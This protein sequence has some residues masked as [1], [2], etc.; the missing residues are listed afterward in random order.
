M[1]TQSERGTVRIPAGDGAAYGPAGRSAWLDVDWREHQRWVATSGG[2]VNAV[3]LGSGPPVLF[4]HGLSGCWPN[5]LEQL[6]ALAGS[7]R[8]IAID[9]PGFGHSPMPSRRI[10]MA[11]YAAMLDELLDEL[12]V[13]AA[14]VVGNSMGG[15]IACELAI[16]FP[17]RVQRL[18]LVSAAGISTQR[19]AAGGANLIWMQRL[20]RALSGGG[21]YFARRAETVARH[22]R[23]RE[24]GLA[25][26]VAHPG[27]LPPAISCELI[28]GAGKPG[29]LP[30]LTSMMAHELRS[31]LAL[32]RCPTLVVWGERDRAV[33]VRDGVVFAHLIGDARLVVFEDTGHVAMVERPE[34]F[35]AL[36]EE[37]LG[38]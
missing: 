10:S 30:A 22:R 17:E 35:N 5:W 3:D 29:F 15:L 18:V 26:F 8:V 23:L 14:A 31:R 25:P 33:S 16:S 21:G 36:L 19:E 11:A 28:R 7:R 9:L 32:I 1:S 2:P 37:F 20:E 34:G 6:G 24:A 38:S 13:P 27:R 4:V 12:D